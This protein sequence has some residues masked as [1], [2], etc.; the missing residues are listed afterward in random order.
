MGWL[1]SHSIFLFMHYTVGFDLRLFKSSQERYLYISGIITQ[2]KYFNA[3]YSKIYKKREVLIMVHPFKYIITTN[4]QN[5]LMVSIS[6][7]S[8]WVQTLLLENR[9][10]EHMMGMTLNVS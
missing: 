9:N 3:L 1:A 5:T 7:H 6:G 4:Q 10:T 8:D 2:L